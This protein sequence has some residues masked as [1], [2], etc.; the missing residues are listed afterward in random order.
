M[1]SELMFLT[2]AV[3]M[4]VSVPAFSAEGG[5]LSASAIRFGVA[6]GRVLIKADDVD[7][8]GR[9]GGWEL[10]GGFEFNRY[11][12]IEAGYIIGGKAKDNVEGIV[13]EDDTSMLYASAI[14]SLPLGDT[15]SVYARAGLLDWKSDRET[16]LD[17]VVLATENVDGNDP[18]VGAGFAAMIDD[19]LLRL[20]Y[21]MA[22][23]D[24][25]ELRF[26]SLAIA[27]RF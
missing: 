15:A 11:F 22:D 19:A 4:L 14:G 7:L 2:G 5:F 17:G 1:R 24:D 9:T 23:L 10:F 6:G 18:F 12:A 26:V 8:R 3:A 13:I 16:R 25:T 20:E 27:W 21:R